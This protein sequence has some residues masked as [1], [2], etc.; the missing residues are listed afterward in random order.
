MIHRLFIMLG[1]LALIVT[2]STPGYAG[3]D[4]FPPNEVSLR[5]LQLQPHKYAGQELTFSHLDLID[6]A[7]SWLASTNRK[8]GRKT[9][10]M[11]M[12]LSDTSGEFSRHHGYKHDPKFI[13]PPSM[14][15]ALL[16]Y[17]ESPNIMNIT[18]TVL[19]MAIEERILLLENLGRSLRHDPSIIRWAF[20]IDRIQIVNERNEEQDVIVTPENGIKASLL[21]DVNKYFFEDPEEAQR[22]REFLAN[23]FGE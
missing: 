4:R 10:F 23:P 6:I 16:P 9:V 8:T 1:L 7:E 5:G 3:K 18:G 11:Y 22:R 20:Y 17:L 13:F 15:D 14:I 12:S 19:G 21:N 2:A